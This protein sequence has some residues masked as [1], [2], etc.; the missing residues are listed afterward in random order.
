MALTAWDL[1]DDNTQTD[2]EWLR[3][4]D[5]APFL[6]ITQLG[7]VKRYGRC[8]DPRSNAS[9]KATDHQLRHAIGRALQRRSNNLQARSSAF[10]PSG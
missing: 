1:R 5:T 4:H 2:E 6:G 8:L 3:R 7:L 10:A 9:D